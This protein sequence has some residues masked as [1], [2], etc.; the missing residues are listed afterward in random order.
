MPLRDHFRS[1]LDKVTSWR[2]FHGGWP[3][4]VVQLRKPKARPPE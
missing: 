1:P 3:T 2:G 4:V